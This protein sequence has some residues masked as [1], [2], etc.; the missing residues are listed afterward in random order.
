M[1]LVMDTE[2][3]I[4]L[5][6]LAQRQH[7]VL[8]RRQARDLGATKPDLRRRLASPDWEAIGPRVL[9]LVGSRRTFE[10]RCM[11]AAL[12]AGRDA[13]VSHESAAALWGLPGF[14]R[15]I[16]AVTR[17]R[18]GTRR[19][20]LLATVHEPRLLP[21]HHVTSL[22][23]IPIT[24]VART[25][26]DLAGCVHPRRSER[27]LDNALARELTSLTALDVLA[28]ELVQRGRTGSGVIRLLMAERGPSYVPP[29]S[30]LEA[31][32]VALL[33][34]AGLPP[35]LRQVDVGAEWV[36]RV[37]FLYP[38]ERLV[39]EIDSAVH[40]GSK[41]D[42]EAD[43]GRDR[44]LR[45]AGFEVLRVSD[46]ELRERP[47]EAL[48]RVKTALAT[49]AAARTGVQKGLLSGPLCTPVG[50]GVRTR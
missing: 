43:A 9:R 17:P 3:D 23:G 28:G 5:R 40:H 34:E 49:R 44:A 50:K 46:D 14:G 36:G 47:E 27:A 20:T 11:T 45:A 29:A 32:F 25:L 1:S 24:T 39:I 7:C 35:P 37:D 41:L 42:K 2:L 19:P 18:G 22:D 15:N 48:R 33:A 6:A 10:Q 30:G 4:A 31:R 8:S 21:D 13:A 38:P 26:F 12:D 16:V